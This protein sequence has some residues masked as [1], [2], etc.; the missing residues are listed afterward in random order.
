MSLLAKI[1]TLLPVMIEEFMQIAMFDAED[2]YYIKQQAVGKDGDFITAPEISQVFGEILAANIAMHQDGDFALVELGS[3]NGTLMNDVLRTLAKLNRSPSKIYIVEVNEAMQKRQQD[4]LSDCAI[5]W[6]TDFLDIPDNLSKVVIANEF[7]DCFPIKQFCG[8]EEV[9][10]TKDFTFSHETITRE[11]SPT[12]LAY[13]QKVVD[14]L[15]GGVAFIFDYGYLE[16]PKTSTLQAIY[17]HQKVSPL[18]YI[19][20]ADLTALVDFSSFYNIKKG[21]ILP[22]REFLINGGAIPR[23]AKLGQAAAL[24]RILAMPNFFAMIVK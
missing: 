24:E 23:A 5:S 21:I 11:T 12:A 15:C 20:E 16:N 18:E 6:T 17:K 22:Q 1:K 7:F 8:D 4:N 19:G 2:G 14:N 10:I 13:Y 3:G 9:Y